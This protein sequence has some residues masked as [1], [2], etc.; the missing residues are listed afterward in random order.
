MRRRGKKNTGGEKRKS[1]GKKLSA[2]FYLADNLHSDCYLVSRF[3]P[4]GMPNVES[5]TLCIKRNVFVYI[6]QRDSKT[7]AHF[8]FAEM[9]MRVCLTVK[10]RNEKH[11]CKRKPFWEKNKNAKVFFTYNGLWELKKSFL[12][13]R[14]PGRILQEQLKQ[15]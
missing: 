13:I 5:T 12:W 8:H 6:K 1:V 4:L 10:D 7:S 15:K 9:Y 2:F 3:K 11:C 14:K